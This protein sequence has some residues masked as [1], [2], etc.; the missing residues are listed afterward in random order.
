[1]MSSVNLAGIYVHIPFCT[2]K[3]PYCDFLS[4]GGFGEVDDLYLVALAAEM[5]Y[6]KVSLPLPCL[7]DTIYFGGGTPSLLTPQQVE[8]ILTKLRQTFPLGSNLEVTL[9]ANPGSLSSQKLRG[10]RQAGVNRLSLGVQALDPEDL[11]ILGRRHDAKQARESFQEA[12]AAGFEDINIDLI[13]GIP[14]Q[15]LDRWAKTLKEIVRWGPVHISPYC[16]TVEPGTPLGEQVA[17]GKVV[18][19]EDALQAEMYRYT[20][21]FLRTAGYEH[22]EI[23][24][25]SRQRPCRHNLHYWYNDWYLGLGWGA[26]SHFYGARFANETS[27]ADYLREYTKPQPQIYRTYL[28]PYV[29]MQET[30]FMGLRLLEEG[31]SVERF[32]ERFGKSPYTVFSEELEHLQRLGLIQCLPSRIRLSARGVFF[33]NR[34]F[35]EFV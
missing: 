35:A 30:M 2:S 12:V 16:L 17:T 4:L 14:G 33:G 18:V 27:L 19:P 6:L 22:Y 28:S 32:V 29:C 9:E 5:D 1:M 11:K 3:C 24:N 13:F 20:I 34:V 21:D 26:H 8:R 15:S 10:Y 23:S 31:V 7:F 25:F